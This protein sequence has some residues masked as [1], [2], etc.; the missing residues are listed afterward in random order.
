[1]ENASKALIMA[2]GI[3]ISILVLS[4]A[5]Y[6]FASFGAQSLQT[7]KQIE[8]ERLNQFNVQ[9]TSYVGKEN[10]TIYD[11]VT[12][13]NLATENN[14]YYEYNKRNLNSVTGEDSYIAV[15][16]KDINLS[17]YNNRSI[18]MG[19]DNY[20][21]TYY[22]KLIKDALMSSVNNSQY[23]CRVEIS[24]LTSKVYKVFFDKK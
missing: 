4:I 7:H 10:I 11:V 23:S 22:D 9:F 3:L 20:D 8:E 18:E 12:V 21:S 24:S 14:M 1:M 15:Y 17:D 13:A 6:L 2:A 19:I 16:F 5:V